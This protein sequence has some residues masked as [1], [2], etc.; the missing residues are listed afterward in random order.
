MTIKQLP[1]LSFRLE[2]LRVILPWS[3]VKSFDTRSCW[4]GLHTSLVDSFPYCRKPAI[5]PRLRRIISY[6]QT[7]CFSWWDSFPRDA[8]WMHWKMLWT[9]AS[10][11]IGQPPNIAKPWFVDFCWLLT[12][13]KNE[14]V[15]IQL[16]LVYQSMKSCIE[17]SKT[18]GQLLTVELLNFYHLNT[19]LVLRQQWDVLHF[20][21]ISTS[22][23]L[24]IYIYICISVYIHICIHINDLYIY[25]SSLY[26]Y[27]HIYIYTYLYI[28]IHIHTHIYIYIRIHIHIYID[29]YIYIY[30]YI[31]IYI[32]CTYIYV[33]VYVYIYRHTSTYVYTYIYIYWESQPLWPFYLS[34]P[35]NGSHLPSHPW[36]GAS[37]GPTSSGKWWCD[38]LFKKLGS[39]TMYIYIYVHIY[40]HVYMYIYIYTHIYTHVYIYIRIFIHMYIYI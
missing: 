10:N 25:I 8:S 19:W 29:I 18:A 21:F 22:L 11:C 23:S 5:G 26:I 28:Y 14:A 38:H 39:F 7:R 9:G 27:I 33:D 4:L 36:G 31:C 15:P 6:A 16:V 2:C 17:V 13:V 20:I 32:Y 30:I 24:Y 40:T 34:L 12:D 3:N 35:A 37:N 1:G